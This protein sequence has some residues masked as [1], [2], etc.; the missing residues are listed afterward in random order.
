MV[1]LTLFTLLALSGLS[2]VAQAA[3]I[4][5]VHHPRAPIPAPVPVPV[6][7]PVASPVTHVR[8]RRC[9]PRNNSNLEQKTEPYARISSTS[10]R[11]SSSASHT[12]THTS[13]A[14]AKTTTAPNPANSPSKGGSSNCFPALGFN[15]PANV[16]SSLDG[17]WCDDKTEYAFLGF[18]YEVSACQS[19]SQLNSE[20][21]DIR[22]RF[23]GRYVRLYGACDNNGFYDDVVEA[24]YANG[25]GVQALIWFGFDGGSQ[26]E[27]RRD[28]LFATIHSN[29]K[30]KFVTRAVQFGSE[31]LLDG[32][33]SPSD[34]AAQV[35]SA[36]DQLASLGIAVTVSDMQY[37][38][39][40]DGGSGLKVLDA[41]DIFDAHMLPFFAG[42]ATTAQASWPSIKSGIDNFWVPQANGRKIYLTENGWPS[43][44]ENDSQNPNS[45]SA[46]A[47]VS[48]EKAYFDMLDE[49]CAYF[50]SVPGGG[51]GW[52]A[53]IYSDAQE[54]GYGILND[55]GNLKFA[56]SP[57]THC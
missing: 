35:R 48:Q 47:S 39:Q 9:K 54:G 18:S 28:S 1:S 46:Q 50:K 34:L 29:P 36:Q 16:P 13:A 30:A 20:F 17:W 21:A 37:S 42:D 43:A 44:V 22:K 41:V 53:H 24:A 31:P 45:A 5:P 38:F 8:Q 52:F 27:Q 51:V 56:F 57:K 12:S 14:P 6:A 2:S 11:P 19:K 55:A 3:H 25:L 10:A 32:V 40:K 26:W 7:A 15:P 33:L 23:N 4:K 49:N